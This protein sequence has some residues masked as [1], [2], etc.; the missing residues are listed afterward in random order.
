M[1]KLALVDIIN[2]PADEIIK[3]MMYR[4]EIPTVVASEPPA[5]KRRLKYKLKGFLKGREDLLKKGQT[6]KVD[7]NFLKIVEVQLY[8]GRVMLE[9]NF[10]ERFSV[11]M[12]SILGQESLGIDKGER[13][14]FNEH[15]YNVIA[16]N[17]SNRTVIIS[18]GNMKKKVNIKHVEKVT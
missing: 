1:E 10:G 13:V 15:I 6:F 16:V 3:R 11:S 2:L 4:V 17:L 5:Q 18:D 14:R 9:T 7:S 8:P 12:A